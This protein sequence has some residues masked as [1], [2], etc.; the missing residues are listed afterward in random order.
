[1]TNEQ[2]HE[3][4]IVALARAAIS[5]MLSDE[6]LHLLCWHAG[7][8]KSE[9]QGVKVCGYRMNDLPVFVH[10]AVMENNLREHIAEEQ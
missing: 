6:D 4:T 2:L 9:L 1:M 8:D 7:V 3:R 5:P 10:R